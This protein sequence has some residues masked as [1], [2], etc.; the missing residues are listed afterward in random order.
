[1]ALVDRNVDKHGTREVAQAYLD[2]LYA[3][4]A[5][6]IAARHFYRPIDA[7]VAAKYSAQFPPLS[8]FT[9]DEVFGGWDKAQNEHFSDGGTFD[10]IYS[11]K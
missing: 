10:R 9:V 4:Q 11:R 6:E 1:M 2:F 5:Q 3:P 7:Q 8:L